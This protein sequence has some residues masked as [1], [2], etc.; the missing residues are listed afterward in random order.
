MLQ[1]LTPTS[2]EAHLD[3]PFRIHYGENT[4]EVMLYEVKAHEPHPGTRTQPFS[5]YFRSPGQLGALPQATYRLEHGAMETMEIFI[6]PIG[7]DPKGG[8][9]RYE[10][11]F[12]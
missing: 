11:V 2:F 1:D 3:T 4:L 7:P 5:I 8:G 9:M 10:A 12:N 6:V